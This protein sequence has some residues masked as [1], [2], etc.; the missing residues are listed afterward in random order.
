MIDINSNMN[1][2]FDLIFINK[3]NE[4]R[5]GVSIFGWKCYITEDKSLLQEIYAV[6]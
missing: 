5:I 6:S 2:L 3:I 1:W 4:E